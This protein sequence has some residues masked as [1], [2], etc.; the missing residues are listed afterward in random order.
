MKIL[1]TF[2]PCLYAFKHDE[3]SLDELERVFDQWADPMFLYDFFEKNKKDISMPIEKAISKVNSEAIFLRNKLL[4]LANKTPNQLSQLFK[5]LSNEE[6]ITQELSKQ[7]AP[8]R[9][10]R[11]YAIRIDE[12]NYVITGGTIKLDGGAIA[13]NNHYQMQDR[14]HTNNELNKINKCRDYLKD[15]GVIDNDS[16]QE[17]F[18]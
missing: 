7:K 16:F 12:N 8:N 13:L 18:F 11:L 5:N 3:N 1:A 2:V 10:L 6:Y 15:E 17:I 9:W 4:E 14:L